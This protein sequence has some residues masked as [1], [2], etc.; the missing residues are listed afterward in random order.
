MEG[1]IY[2]EA[3]Y[4]NQGAGSLNVCIVQDESGVVPFISSI[5]AVQISVTLYPEMETNYAYNLVSR[6]N[7]GGGEVR[8]ISLIIRSLFNICTVVHTYVNRCYN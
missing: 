3:M 8:Y 5:E 6:I 4:V 2:H 7:Y 1:P